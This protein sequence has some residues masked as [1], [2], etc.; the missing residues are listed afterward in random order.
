M[1]ERIL[2][3]SK[4]LENDDITYQEARKQLCDLFDVKYKS[5][6][7]GRAIVR[8]EGQKWRYEGLELPIIGLS[9]VMKNGYGVF[10]DGTREFR[11]SLKD[12]QW[13]EE[14]SYTVI[15]ETDLIILELNED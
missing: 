6:Y 12:T 10:P 9:C 14:Q 11:L 13:G 15:P 1:K 8:S 4:E 5:K 2:K 3:I 7:S